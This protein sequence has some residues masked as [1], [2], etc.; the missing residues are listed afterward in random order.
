MSDPGLVSD[1]R[2]AGLAAA[3]DVSAMTARLAPL[4]AG[5]ITGE[6]APPGGWQVTAVEVLKH[7]AGR[8]CSLAYFLEGAGGRRVKL[9]AKVFAGERGASIVQNMST[10]ARAI[11]RDRLIIPR[12]LGYLPGIKLMVT[13][14]V[15]GE[16]LASALYRGDT[17][18]AAR[19]MAAALG[20]LHGSD[21]PFAR[22][23][24]AH[25]ELANTGEWLSGLFRSHP[26]L[27]GI[28]RGLLERLAR[29]IDLHREPAP[30]PVHRDF[31]AEQM[32]DCAGRNALLDLDDVRSGDPA[33]DAGN[34]LAH[35]SLRAAQ[36]PE[37]GDACRR[38]RPAFLDEYA[39]RRAG[40]EGA[41][42]FAGRL[43]F[44]ES[45]SLLRLA[46]VYAGRERWT[47]TLPAILVG[48]CQARIRATE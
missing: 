41:E 24:S 10:L 43:A 30:T 17:A 11:P 31:Y 7:K 2:L 8:R 40:A 4:L 32:W 48:A 35:L 12:P 47:E 36:F 5:G 25:R 39:A 6:P 14:F 23:W 42:S 26:E 27:A 22:G 13:E 37:V 33:L 44:Y 29:R 45:A 1:P 21:C 16:P 18:A 20:V 34:F 15:E 46:A 3:L 9:F 38:A 28:A 19:R